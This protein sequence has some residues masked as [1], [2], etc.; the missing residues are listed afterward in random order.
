MIKLL[1]IFTLFFALNCTAQQQQITTTI[2]EVELV[3][4]EFIYPTVWTTYIDNQDIQIEYMFADCDPAMGYDFQQVH[5]KFTNKTNSN[6]ELSWHID[7][8]YNEICKT[9]DY[10]FEYTRTLNLSP[11]EILEGT[12]SRDSANELKLFS[13][14]I[15][16][17]YT[18]GDKLTGFQLQ[19]LTVSEI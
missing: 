13:K 2:I 9:C 3:E 11:S 17:N 6:L 10:E 4:D 14:F 15:D 12:C 16:Q 5:F 7:L 1:T 8:Y 18:K 19:S